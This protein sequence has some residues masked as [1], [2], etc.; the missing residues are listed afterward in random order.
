MTLTKEELNRSYLEQIVRNYHVEHL[1]DNTCE[2]GGTEMEF[3][4]RGVTSSYH[5]YCCP[6]CGKEKWK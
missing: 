6:T 4:P 2:C 5:L 3:K 1:R